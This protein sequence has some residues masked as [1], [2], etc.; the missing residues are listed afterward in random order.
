MKDKYTD[1][2]SID[3]F[4]TSGV[5]EILAQ[6]DLETIYVLKNVKK[7]E[8]VDF[9]LPSRKQ[10]KK[11]LLFSDLALLNTCKSIIPKNTLILGQGG[12]LQS[13]INILSNKSPIHL[14]DPIGQETCIDEGQCRIAHQNKKIVFFNLDQIRNNQY[15]AIKQMSFA[16]GLLK[17][18][19][20]EM[21]FMTLAKRPEDLVD[22]II[23]QNFLKNF[24]LEKSFTKRILQEKI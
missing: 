19:N 16:I 5:P 12:S 11:A 3:L 6:L 21:R 2:V 14:F 9:P 23:L 24:N 18:H 10:F 22:P 1:V 17:K 20:V 4:K 8:D 7:K 15:K 13:N